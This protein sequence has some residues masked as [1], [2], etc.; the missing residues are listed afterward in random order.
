MSYKYVIGC[1]CSFLEI[2]APWFTTIPSKNYINL[3]RGGCGN[4]F[5]KHQIT[6]KIDELI[7]N[8][9]NAQDIFVVVQWTGISRLDFLVSRDQTITPNDFN[10]DFDVTRI[11]SYVMV[12]GGIAPSRI[13]K[14]GGWVH[15]GGGNDFI[16]NW[17][18]KKFEDEFFET[19]FKYFGND[20]D[21]VKR[22]LDNVLFIQNLCKSLGINYVMTNAWNPFEDAYGREKYKRKYF[23][24]MWNR[25]DEKHMIWIESNIK[26]IKT[27]KIEWNNEYGGMWQYLIERD[28]INLKDDHPSEY[29]HK[30]WGNYIFNVLTERKIL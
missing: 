11:G 6:Y 4:E 21:S 19:Y 30:I 14:K 28:G 23:D 10:T 9:I 16:T 2:D 25:V 5:I 3:S 1:G 20:Y 24:Y 26:N 29:G 15:S 13:D 22:Y 18:V 7:S 8:E 12:G 27:E 17:E